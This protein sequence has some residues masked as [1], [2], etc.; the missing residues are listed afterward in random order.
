MLNNTY[1][2]FTDEDQAVANVALKHNF[3]MLSAYDTNVISN[4]THQFKGCLDYIFYEANKLGLLQ[5]TQ[6]LREFC[7]CQ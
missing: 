3:E 5:V 4:Y 7:F 6:I 1:G 2:L